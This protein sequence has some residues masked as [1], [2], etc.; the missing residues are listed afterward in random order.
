MT[1]A[2][3]KASPTQIVQTA[4]EGKNGLL[5]LAYNIRRLMT[6]KRMA[7]HKGIVCQAR[8]IQMSRDIQCCGDVR[9]VNISNV[10]ASSLIITEGKRS[11]PAFFH[12]LFLTMPGG[13]GAPERPR[14][15]ISQQGYQGSSRRCFVAQPHTVRRW[16]LSSAS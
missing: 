7:L 1:R 12:F 11:A 9:V 3:L 15:L 8:D 16:A 2:S 4:G 5:N 13:G 10:S 6:L 14:S